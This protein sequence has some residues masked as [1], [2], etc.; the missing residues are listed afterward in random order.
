MTKKPD[1]AEM[2]ALSASVDD[3]CVVILQAIHD[4]LPP[5]QATSP[6]I[7]LA[8]LV[9]TIIDL[10]ASAPEPIQAELYRV[11]RDGMEKWYVDKLMDKP[12]DA[13]K[14]THS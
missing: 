1:E 12:D 5:G 7:I 11:T 2:Q 13:P 9:A 14:R 4:K 8:A 6:M 10:I 3:L